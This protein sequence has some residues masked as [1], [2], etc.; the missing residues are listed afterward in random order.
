[1]QHT[2][3]TKKVATAK[4]YVTPERL[5]RPFPTSF[6]S[7][8]VYLAVELLNNNHCNCLWWCKSLLYWPPCTVACG[9]LAKPKPVCANPNNTKEIRIGEDG[10]N[11][12][13]WSVNII[14]YTLQRHL[15]RW[16]LTVDGHE[17]NFTMIQQLN[18]IHS[19]V[20]VLI[21]SVRE[22]VN[23]RQDHHSWVDSYKLLVI[24]R[25]WWPTW[26]P[27]WI[28]MLNNVL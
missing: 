16:C 5:L 18:D 8:C 21:T 12:Q 3:L 22:F 13:N 14:F 7:Q 20:N 2:V 6:H 24:Q 1:M 17:L 26:T 11:T 4:A 10:E 28:Y 19:C 23:R 9:G 27:Y 25:F 15:C